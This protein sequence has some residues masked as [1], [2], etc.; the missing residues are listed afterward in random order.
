MKSGLITDTIQAKNRSKVSVMRLCALAYP[1]ANVRRCFSPSVVAERRRRP[2][3]R[4]GYLE[5]GQARSDNF[6]VDVMD[7]TTHIA[8]RTVFGADS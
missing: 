2:V 1:I 6:I 4:R 5:K 3:A 7:L 8:A